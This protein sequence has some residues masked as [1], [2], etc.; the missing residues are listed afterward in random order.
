LDAESRPRRVS[1]IVA[2]DRQRVIGH[3]GRL[4]WHLPEDLK[5]FKSLTMGHAMIMGRKTHESIGRLLPGRRSIIVTRQ[6]DYTVPGAL[7]VHSIEE[8]LK[9]CA[10]EDEVFVIGGAE[11]YAQA[12]ACADRI[13]LTELHDS[14]PGDTWFPPLPEGWREVRRETCAPQ[15]G[16]RFDF[17]VLERSTAT[18]SG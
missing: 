17:V 4:P 9:A 10:G 11:I 1:L 2:M 7:V 6:R 12:L 16:P 5:R 14:V 3:Q 15:I 18:R 13:H 8:A